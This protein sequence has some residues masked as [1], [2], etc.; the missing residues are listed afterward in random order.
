M[1]DAGEVLLGRGGGDV[2]DAAHFIHSHAAPAVRPVTLWEV[3]GLVTEFTG[4]RHG[5]KGPEVF[6][7]EHVKCPNILMKSGHD[8]GSLKY[9][10]ASRS[11]AGFAIRPARQLRVSA[12]A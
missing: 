4:L 7:R 8:D 12:F 2:G 1:P 9:G 6:A 5:M 11:R 10:R 3:P